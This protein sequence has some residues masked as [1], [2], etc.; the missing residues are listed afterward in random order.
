[1]TEKAKKKS[2]FYFIKPKY[3]SKVWGY[4]EMH[5]LLFSKDRLN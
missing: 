3:H 1:M 2:N 4:K 5:A